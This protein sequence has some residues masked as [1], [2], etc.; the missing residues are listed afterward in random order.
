MQGQRSRRQ[1]HMRFPCKW[2]NALSFLDQIENRALLSRDIKVAGFG[3]LILIKGPLLIRDLGALEKI[4]SLPSIRK[5]AEAGSEDT[6]S[7][8]RQQRRQSEKA[9]NKSGPKN[10]TTELDLFFELVKILPHP[11]QMQIGADPTAWAVLDGAGLVAAA[12]D[13]VLKYGGAIPGEWCAVGI[14]D[15]VP[16][17]V[18]ASL[19][20]Q[21]GSGLDEI[22]SVLLSQLEP[23]VRQLLGRPAGAFGITPLLVFREIGARL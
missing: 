18:S 7:G 10:N 9:N 13:F 4:W 12:S 16:D 1:S 8:N 5:I 19:K 14:L 11:A 2:V 20:K 22:V 3:D 17:S 21:H 6:Q 23:V 15:A